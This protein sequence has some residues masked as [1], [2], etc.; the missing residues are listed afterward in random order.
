MKIWEHTFAELTAGL[1]PQPNAGN[2]FWP[3]PFEHR[4][5]VPLTDRPK[6]ATAM[7]KGAAS[8]RDQVLLVRDGE[9][10]R[11]IGH[12]VDDTKA[13]HFMRCALG[14]AWLRQV[15]GLF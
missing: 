12:W 13:E 2:P 10:W 1:P 5:L 9:G 15:G 6:F 7:L 3:Q 4:S 14:D 11:C 8:M